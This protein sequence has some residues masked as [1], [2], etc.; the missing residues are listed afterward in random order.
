[1]CN[2]IKGSLPT[3]KLQNY[4][5]CFLHNKY[6]QCHLNTMSWGSSGF[7]WGK[8]LHRMILLPW[9]M[10]VILH[11]TAAVLYF[12]LQLFRWCTHGN[13]FYSNEYSSFLNFK[14]MLCGHNFRLCGLNPTFNF[15]MKLLSSIFMCT[16]TVHFPKLKFKINLWQY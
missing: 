15:K 9:E 8:S 10:V 16:D 3:W 1:M 13:E 12:P 14:I 6:L 2:Y 4:L 5:K 11:N 7:L